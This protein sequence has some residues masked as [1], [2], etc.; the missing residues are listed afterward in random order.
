MYI[1]VHVQSIVYVYGPILSTDLSVNLTFNIFCL[2]TAKYLVTRDPE[3]LANIQ[4][5][6]FSLWSVTLVS[7]LHLLV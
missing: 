2:V 4:N 1:A 5:R 3:K 7:H 6:H